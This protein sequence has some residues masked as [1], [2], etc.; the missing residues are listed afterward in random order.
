MASAKGQYSDARGVESA[1]KDAAQRAH[2]AD[3]SRQTGDLIRQA[4]FDR[5]LCRI[6]SGGEDCEWVL[7]GG[8]G[9]LARL[10]NAR[11]T[12]DV[13]LFRD[14]FDKDQ[15]ITELRRLAAV[16]LGDFFTFTYR[17]HRPILAND[18]Q[19]SVE[20]YKVI[21]D[22]MLGQKRLDPIR[23]DL[24]AHEARTTGITMADPANR[25]APPKMQAYPYRLYPLPNQVADKVCATVEEHQGR[26]SSRERDLVDLVI[27]A[28]TQRL[29]AD[30]TVAAIRRELGKRRVA[31]SEHLIIPAAWGVGYMRLARGTPAKSHTTDDARALMAIFID[32]L[33]AGTVGGTTWNP[34]TLAWERLEK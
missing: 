22:A 4:H 16:D 9:M 34:T 26:V 30:D 10:V 23:V 6:F 13:D 21:F 20:G 29:D 14:G 7:K 27:I 33:L 8:S 11:R 1:I 18:G 19:P 2:G 31:I 24:T 3:P 32:P 15:S 12:N 5:F 25:L 17:T 28:L